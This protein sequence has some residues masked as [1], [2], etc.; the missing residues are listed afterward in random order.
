ML[1]LCTGFAS[2]AN[3]VED[4]LGEVDIYN[5]GYELAYLSI[6]GRVQ[7]QKYTYYNYI[8][9]AGQQKE[10]PAYCVNPNLYGVPQ[11][12]GV[13]ESI[14][15]LAEEKTSDPKVMGIIA[16]GY[17]TRGLAELKLDN[18][19]QAYYATKMALWCYLISDWNINNLK[20][21]P[22][23]S[24]DELT[25]AQKI[26]AATK[27]IYA[28]GTSWSEILSPNITCTP[29]RD[30]AYAVTVDGKQ[31]KQQVFTFWS[32]TWVCDY[33]VNVGFTDPSSVPKGTRIVDLNNQDITT[34]TTK[35]T[36][37]GFAGQFKVLYPIDSIRGE[38]GSVQL[39][40]STNVYKY[41]VFY[42][43]CQE[44]DTYGNLQNY[45][46]DTDPTT[47]MN[48]SAYSNY[49]DNPEDEPDETGL[50][51]M[52]YE[53]GTE[54]PLSGARF[55]VIGPDGDSIGTFVTDGNGE[56][57]IPLLKTGNYTVIERE[58]PQHY[59]ISKE[60]TQN[61]TVV[62]DKIAEVT[63]FNDPYGNLR[64][65]KKS[66]TGMNLPGAVI[67][68]THIESGQTFTETTS[69]AGVAF[70]DKIPLG[71]YR[72]QEVSAPEGWLLD[73]TVY[74]ATVVAGE[75]T[76]I[77]IINE[78]LPG[79]RIIKY[80]RKNHVAMPNVT[81]E[82][83]RD[84]VSLGKFK[85]DQF[86]EILL[87]NVEPGTYR[88]VEVDTGD[89]GFILDT[90]PQ[91]VELKA[92]DGIKE[93]VFFNDMKPGLKLIKVDSADPSKVIPNAVFEIK[94]VAG[95]YGPEE[96][97]TD[98][99]GEIDLSHLPAGA[100]V[101]T[102]KSCDGYIIDNA[103]RIIQLDPNE[104][105]Q[106]V[107]TNTIRPSLQLIKLS[108]DGSRLAGVT[109][110]IAKIEDGSHYLDR[111]TNSN[112]E[113]LIS[114]LEPGVY[115][116]RETATL[117]DHLL[118][119]TEHHVE[120]F[121]G[122]T[123]T[124]VLENDRRPSL[125]IH[126]NDADTGEPVEGVVFTVK[127]ADGS[128]ITEVKTGPD[129]TAKLENLLP[130]VYEVIEKSVPEPYL[131][132]APSQ[133]ITLYPN[134][135]SD[136][137]FENHKKPS[138]TIEK[139]D[140]ITGDP[141][142]GA[143]FQIWYGSNNTETGEL[144][145]LGTYY[146][147]ADGRIVLENV[148]DGWFK[149]TELEP[150][151]G[152]QI[153]D[154]ATQEC[155]IE[156]GTS[157][158]L[159]FENTPL[160]ALI[161][162]K[163]D[164]VTG[165]P[166]ANA[167]F[168]VKYL[169]GTSGTG[170]TVIGTYKTSVNGSFTVTGLKAGTYIVEELASDS[171]HVIDTAPQTAYISG[172]DQDVVEL[173][174]G[175]SPKGSLLIKKIDSKTHKPLSDVQFFVT[176]SDGTVVGNG[177]G[178]FT[179][180]S[181]G[182]ILIEGIDP[183]TTLVVKETIAKDGY[184]L[185]DTPQTAKI[186]AGQTV[187]LEFR[188]QPKGGLIINKLD[189]VTR[190]PLEGVEF[191]ITYSDG[192]YVDAEGGALSSK[193]LYRT[194]KNGQIILSELTGTVVVTETKTIDGYTIHEETRTQTVV[195]NPGDTQTITVYNDP[196]GGVEIIKVNAS[197]TSERI[198]D[199][200]FEIRR[201][202]D[203]LVGTITTD[204]N[205]RAFLALEDGA[206]YA[207]EI[208][209]NPD[210]VLDDTPHYFEVKDGKVTSLR[211][212]NAAKSGILIHKVDTSGEGIYGVKF[213]L[214]DEDRNPIGEFTSD[215]NGYVY[216]TAEDLPDGANTSGRFY[217]RELEAAE[218]YILDKEY[219]TVYVRPGRT[220]EIEWVNEAITGQIQIYKYAAEANPVTGDPAGTPLKGAVYE[221]INERSGKVVDYITTDARGVAASKPLPLTR[222]KIREVT[223]PAYYQIDPTVH[224]VTLEY[225]G[226]I[227]KIAAYDK[228]ANLKVTVTKTGNKQLLAGDSMRYD[229]TVANN[230][231]VAL[232]NFYL[233]DRFPTDCST[234]KT[235][236]TGTYNTRLNYRITYK[237]NYNDYRV[238]ATN[239]LSTNNY[240]FDLTAVSLMQGEVITDVRLE[241]GKVP[242]GFASVVKPT[243]TIQT[244][245]SL[246]NGYQV[247]NRADA[248]G[249]Y[250]SQW[251]TGRAAWITII[252]KLNQPNL[253]KTGY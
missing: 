74:T 62:Y 160:S 130:I 239:L 65:E 109:F 191:E 171:G 201:M 43:V 203:A 169:S 93:L 116:V 168:Q 134:K 107:F 175:N 113:I 70:F 226:Q 73:D 87:T 51:I 14:S 210:F 104:D 233:H 155:F 152:Y 33:T 195:I 242:A 188:N 39:S 46:V 29:D 136:I 193:G 196:V 127:A 67:T 64:I 137:Y 132:D 165:E 111:T 234:V 35:D 66:N 200:T 156:A 79:L 27:D 208:E 151:P 182:T 146:T 47:T 202:D 25:R 123:S 249:Q 78:E 238:L 89:D 38:T 220:A 143:K 174:F 32:K 179:T 227:I 60:P 117:E 236:T 83:F 68:I 112:G 88:A 243:V 192:S 189:S 19:Y 2:A 71:A 253:P 162:Y 11:T 240:A 56:I 121:P 248:G 5:G 131:L 12:V 120:L 50:R 48:L 53:T 140:S 176:E 237:T 159:V 114:D 230:S 125:T 167:V 128:T 58:A 217:L 178:Y 148:N 40:F 7:S 215:D 181:Q 251:E 235:I 13:G 6:N 218:G 139:I 245:G 8:N 18:K 102:E 85:T 211:V 28:R 86:G 17:P 133:L 61:V 213:L 197:K 118:D 246:A 231:N 94:S 122:Q 124:I 45:V 172:K 158:T 252:L 150:A 219:K 209:A 31:Y 205:G 99:N 52:K 207:L 44:K 15:Y 10:I 216:I 212:T 98:Q 190:K 90:T 180:D 9:A 103:Q 23:L 1:S 101:V 199:T 163:Y 154:P 97:V 81:F 77:P 54:L 4:A 119:T 157:K 223:A 187:T 229:L 69:S 20:I 161:V 82:I 21:N 206:Y 95:D 222:Y 110:R 129:G 72:I 177:N 164:S 24:G 49:A 250:M 41:A 173:Y 59:L 105:A 135:D 198:P 185:D 145:D 241:F 42:A 144:N 115:S 170:G 224:D 141:I 37:D 153:K 244:S 36:G 63:F 184:L 30:T 3:T 57:F 96:F 100:Y 22:S 106:F 194:D 75:T 166:V 247:V 142:K 138:L 147:D 186:Q 16:N 221:I 26:L 149:V 183:G 228:P 108:A 76:T 214:Y 204:D 55:E 225:A 126:K 91:E 232:E 92:G 80:D 34:I 84:G